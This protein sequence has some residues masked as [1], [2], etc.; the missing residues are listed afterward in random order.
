M[1]HRDPLFKGCTR[2]PMIMGVPMVPFAVMVGLLA[3]LSAWV[4]LLVLLAGIPIYIIMRVVT[5]HDDQQF[6]LLFLKATFYF[7]AMSTVRF[8]KACASAPLS[9]KKNKIIPNKKDMRTFNKQ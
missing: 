4:N 9:F 3:L 8:W 5:K 7:P 1:K 2:P 6:R